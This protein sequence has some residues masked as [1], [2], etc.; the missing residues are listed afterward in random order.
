MGYTP[1]RYTPAQRQAISDWWAD[2]LYALRHGRFPIPWLTVYGTPYR[3]PPMPKSGPITFAFT[4][5]GYGGADDPYTTGNKEDSG[6]NA[7]NLT[8]LRKHGPA[9]RVYRWI[10]RARALRDMRAAAKAG[11]PIYLVGHSYGGSTARELSEQLGS[12]VETLTT[13]DPVSWVQSSDRKPDNVGAWYN[14]LPND[15]SLTKPDNIMA[16]LGGQWGESSAATQNIVADRGTHDELTYLI[17]SVFDRG[18]RPYR[19]PAS[20]MAEARANRP[21]SQ[22]A[23]EGAVPA[24]VERTGPRVENL[25]PNAADSW[26]QT[27]GGSPAGV[28]PWYSMA[29]GSPTQGRSA[30]HATPSHLV[31]SSAL[32]R[33]DTAGLAGLAGGALLGGLGG[34]FMP[35]KN[36]RRRLRNA[37]LLGLTG[38]AA[39]A[40]LGRV[41][42]SHV[43]FTGRRAAALS[44]AAGAEKRPGRVYYVDHPDNSTNISNT[45]IGPVDSAVSRLM[46]LTG[47]DGVHNIGHAGIM[48]VDSDGNAT[49]YDYGKFGRGPDAEVLTDRFSVKGLSDAEIAKKL[50]GLQKH[51]GKTVNLYAADVPD[52][53][54]AERYIQGV[55]SPGSDAF[56]PIPGGYTCGSVARDAFEAARGGGLGHWLDMLAGGYPTANAPT[57]RTVQTGYSAKE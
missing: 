35:A 21:Q 32:S 57:Y 46:K 23:S 26:I 39:G 51:W 7:A 45:G 4:G 55:T 25:V 17:H 56:S 41:G 50:Q 28:V 42:A 24:Q 37:L 43:D 52:I 8:W 27:S 40:Y 13:A 31:K 54:V 47:W 3:N 10:D 36:R 33:V 11:H 48:T 2:R 38:G 1:P 44:Q 5:A 22:S 6:L 20:S 9:L 18:F 15:N 53:G 34:Y 14:V 29:P 30:S 49:T 16:T 19:V 12:R